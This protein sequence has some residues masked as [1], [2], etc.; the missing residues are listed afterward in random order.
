LRQN[1][2]RGDGGIVVKKKRFTVEHI[3]GI[4]K[5]AELGTPI[6]E[7]CRQHGVSEQSYYRWK[8]T[9]GA[10][11]PAEVREL[12]Q[13]RDENVKLKRLVADLSLDKAMLQDVLQK[14]S[15]ARQEA[16]S[17][18]VLDGQIRSERQEGLSVRTAVPVGVL[19]PEPR[20]PADGAQAAYARDIE[21]SH[22]RVRFGY[23]RIHM[24]LKREGWDVGKKRFYRVYREENLGLRRTRLWRHISAAQ[25]ERCTNV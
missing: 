18:E 8:K 5:R 11:E 17:G 23:R 16:R 25:R 7:L 9:Y 21:I 20:R 12:K 10:M 14:N 22:A 3:A 15:E 2:V 13:L 6:A 19:L 4:L 1:Q 24:L